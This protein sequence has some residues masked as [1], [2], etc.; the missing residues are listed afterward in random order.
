MIKILNKENNIMTYLVY[1]ILIV[2]KIYKVIIYN[3]KKLS[4]KY[5][6]I[7]INQ[8]PKALK[9]NTMLESMY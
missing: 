7:Y 3:L 8:V 5:I 9:G 6:I 2:L 1:F 4:K